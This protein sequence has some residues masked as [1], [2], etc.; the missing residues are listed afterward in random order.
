M[1]A[2]HRGQRVAIPDPARH[3][4]RVVDHLPARGVRDAVQRVE[5]EEG[6]HPGPGCAVLG[7]QQ[8]QRAAQEGYQL[9]VLAE[10]VALAEHEG[11]Q[12]LGHAGAVARGLGVGGRLA[13]RAVGPLVARQPQGAAAREV[14]VEPL[15]DGAVRQPL[16]RAQ[17][18]LVV[19]GGDVER[20]AGG[21]L[22]AG[23]AGVTQRRAG[24][25]EA[26]GRVEVRGQLG[27]RDGARGRRLFERLCHARVQADAAAGG[28][29]P[30]DGLS[31]EGVREGEPVEGARRADE[32][33]VLGCLE[34]VERA[35]GVDPARG[36]G[37][38]DVEFRARHRGDR[39]DLGRAGGEAGE[40]PA[41][42]VADARRDRC[43]GRVALPERPHHLADEERIALRHGANPRR[44][45]GRPP[46]VGEDGRDVGLGE[47]G[48][49]QPADV[50]P[51]RKP[52]D[53]LGEQR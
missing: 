22:V 52:R 2:E 48:E 47:R 28:K 27:R 34:R 16:V 36:R 41:H 40:P 49:L 35:L 44:E 38:V 53:H 39:Q 23:L 25:D 21:R 24:I 18:A 10:Q 42:D 6:L 20:E 9:L 1:R 11:D 5:R 19:L 30:D 31:H 14:E 32:P 15:L 12:G 8:G 26:A 33:R 51:A 29:V 45:R 3:R 7:G 17:G 4:E 37:D 50:G 43:L 46:G 13:E